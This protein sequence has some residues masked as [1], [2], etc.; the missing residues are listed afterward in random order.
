MKTKKTVATANTREHVKIADKN[1]AEDNTERQRTKVLAKNTN[2]GDSYAIKP[3]E[4]MDMVA[5]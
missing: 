4:G 5:F 2:L 1:V 3:Q